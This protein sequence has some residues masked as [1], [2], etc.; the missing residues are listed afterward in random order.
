[1]SDCCRM[2]VRSPPR[3]RLVRCGSLVWIITRCAVAR[4]S[5][6]ARTSTTTTLRARAAVAPPAP[7]S[8]T[9]YGLPLLP[10]QAQAACAGH[11][12]SA[13]K[14]FRASPKSFSYG[15]PRGARRTLRIGASKRPTTTTTTTTTAAA[16]APPLAG[17][18][19][20]RKP[21]E[22]QR[23]V[24]R[25][26]RR[27]LDIARGDGGGN[28]TGNGGDWPEDYKEMADR[29]T[30]ANDRRRPAM[31]RGAP[32]RSARMCQN[33]GPRCGH[34]WHDCKPSL[35][36]LRSGKGSLWSPRSNTTAA[37]DRRG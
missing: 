18:W 16:A 31:L 29:C 12:A 23:L 7:A 4:R 21:A 25:R 11:P 34:I 27:T 6:A 15:S 30:A 26:L 5:A 8:V 13:E 33:F 1:M 32:P 3:W 24:S 37:N 17:V 14:H 28:G 22:R 35:P 10:Y 20:P 9:P 19:R 2:R 36:P